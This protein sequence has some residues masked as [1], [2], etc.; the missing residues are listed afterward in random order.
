MTKA[1]QIVPTKKLFRVEEDLQDYIVLATDAADALKLVSDEYGLDDVEQI[2]I[3]VCDGD[4]V[5]L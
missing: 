4:V 2:T 5:E 1:K 3:E